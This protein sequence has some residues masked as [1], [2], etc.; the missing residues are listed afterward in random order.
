MSLRDGHSTRWLSEFFLVTFI[1]S[2]SDQQPNPIAFTL[3]FSNIYPCA[4]EIFEVESGMILIRHF[5]PAVLTQDL[6]DELQ[7]RCHEHNAAS[8]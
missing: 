2:H 1:N 3:Q 5:C 8:N 6:C 4:T 7:R